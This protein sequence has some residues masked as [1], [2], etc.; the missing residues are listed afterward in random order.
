MSGLL[1]LVS[2]LSIG[3]SQ[4]LA[5]HEMV[6]VFRTLSG[7]AV[8]LSVP[9]V[10]IYIGETVTSEHRG[11]CGS[12]PALLHAGGVLASYLLGT[13]LPWHTLSFTYC[14]PALLLTLAMAAMPESPLHLAHGG[15]MTRAEDSLMWLRVVNRDM[16]R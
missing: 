5:S 13:W 11:V 8:G 12:L 15:H 10:T 3:L 1:F 14:V 9:A 16:A 7:A 4:S 2:F 6:L